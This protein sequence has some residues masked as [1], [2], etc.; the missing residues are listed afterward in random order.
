MDKH[1]FTACNFLRKQING[2]DFSQLNQFFY[3]S[4]FGIAR[5]SSPF[6][7]MVSLLEPGSTNVI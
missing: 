6:F 1:Q 3:R 2:V 7:R 5:C 4:G